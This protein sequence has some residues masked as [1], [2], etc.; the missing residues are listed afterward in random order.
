MMPIPALLNEL[1]SYIQHYEV[2]CPGVSK[3]SVG[4]HID[5]TL[6]TMNLI[7]DMMSKSDPEAYR[8]K[9]NVMRTLVCT[10]G[11]IPRGKAKAPDVVQPKSL[12]TPDSLQLQL[13][14]ARER[15]ITLEK[16]HQNQYFIHPFFGDLNRKPTI[17]FL[18]IHTFH[19]VKIIRDIISNKVPGQ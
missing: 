6:L 4:W 18:K 8:W 2:S 15:L 14:G 17:R 13:G 12:I 1:E 7:I 9:F 10:T 5:H 16:L 3:G 11:K 19:H